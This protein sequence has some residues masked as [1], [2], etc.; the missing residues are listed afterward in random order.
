MT[1]INIYPDCQVELRKD[2]VIR[3]ANGQITHHP[4]NGLYRSISGEDRSGYGHLTFGGHNLANSQ[5]L[6]DVNVFY[7]FFYGESSDVEGREAW[8][9]PLRVEV[10]QRLSS[11][12]RTW[13][14][15]FVGDI[16]DASS[17]TGYTP[18]TQEIQQGLSQEEKLDF[19]VVQSELPHYVG[20]GFRPRLFFETPNR[21]LSH[22]VSRYWSRAYPGLPIEGYNLSPGQIGLLHKWDKRPRDAQLFRDVMNEISIAFYTF[23]A[24]HRHFA[25]VT[26][27]LGLDDMK[28]LLDI[29]SLRRQARE[30]CG[31]L[32][33]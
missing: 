1:D 30:I 27:K 3:D 26:S 9:D 5:L 32:A 24:E 20:K 15:S 17:S 8:A 22:V 13:Y 23:P 14:L 21:L 29:E 19:A 18:I 12:N 31:R 33:G 28:Q 10:L 16:P 6:D 25:F 11:E 4:L 7:L 2:E